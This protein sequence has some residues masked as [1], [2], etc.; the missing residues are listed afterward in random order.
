MIT[1]RELGRYGR[2]GNQLFQIA[3]T[4]G[5]AVH[6]GYDYAFPAWINYDHRD[7]FKSK[8]DPNVY[9]HFLNPLPYTDQNYPEHYIEWGYHGLDHP[10]NRSYLGHLQSP[11][12]FDHCKDLIKHYFTPKKP[13]PP[14]ECTA[15]HLRC[16]DYGSDYHP[17]QPLSYYQDAMKLV[18]GPY[19]IF[20]DEPQKAKEL[21][22]PDFEYDESDYLTALFRMMSCKRF[23]IANSTFSWWPAYLSVGKTVA[24]QMWFGPRARHL[25]V[26]DLYADGW[27]VI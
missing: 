1:Y 20:S 4:I 25:S 6:N 15:V 8:E 18:E 16:G 23:I 27:E 9:E 21:F 26:K 13:F 12:Y 24:P 22:G 11:K 2:A 17:I 19:L 5:I 14:S 7:R 3:S 10:D